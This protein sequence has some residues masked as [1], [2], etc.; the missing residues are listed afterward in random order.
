MTEF[1]GGRNTAMKVPPHQWDE[2][3]AGIIHLVSKR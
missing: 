1:S 3:P 2:T